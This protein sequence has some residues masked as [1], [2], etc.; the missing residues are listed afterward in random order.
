MT[1][2]TDQCCPDRCRTMIAGT[3]TRVL[4]ALVVLVAS[5]SPIAGYIRQPGPRY[6]AT[7]GHPWPLPKTWTKSDVT[8]GID[9]RSFK[10]EVA[11]H[12]C[13]LLKDAI[14]RYSY[15]IF[16]TDAFRRRPR[17]I[18]VRTS[19]D[20][21]SGRHRLSNVQPRGSKTT[22]VYTKTYLRTCRHRNRRQTKSPHYISICPELVKITRIWE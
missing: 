17:H 21:L 22:T 3:G 6:V 7:V 16:A 15:I 9:R 2:I 8:F 13:D 11:E 20:D 1:T 10:F 5:A 18:G 19:D 14:K 4:C 12:N